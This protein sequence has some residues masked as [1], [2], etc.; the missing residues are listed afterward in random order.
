MEITSKK[1]PVSFKGTE[2]ELLEF[3]LTK[4]G[5]SYYIKNLIR[6][7]MKKVDTPFVAKKDTDEFNFDF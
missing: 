6:E 5:F 4:G 1:K 2:I 3:A 7:D